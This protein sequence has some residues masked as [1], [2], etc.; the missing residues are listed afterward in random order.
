MF[1]EGLFGENAPVV[2]D[3]DVTALPPGSVTG[4][5]D[6]GTS[7]AAP[8]ETAPPATGGNEEPST[9]SQPPTA[10]PSEPS[11]PTSPPP[12]P[13]LPGTSG[14][15][16]G[17]TEGITGLTGPLA[18]PLQAITETLDTLLGLKSTP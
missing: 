12:S 1:D 2:P 14:G 7:V 11:A 8:P 6:D 9:P 3:V 16:T 13:G 10:A 18:E 17:A 4:P 15:I 5:Q